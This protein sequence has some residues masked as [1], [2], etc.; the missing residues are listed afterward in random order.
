MVAART[1]VVDG[2]GDQLLAGAGLPLNEHG[3]VGRG[4]EL[5][6]PQHL[7]Q[8]GAVAHQPLTRLRPAVTFEQ[9]ETAPAR[10]LRRGERCLFGR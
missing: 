9:H 2:L 4:H 10:L 7:A 8:G 5:Q 6:L 3:R 1:P